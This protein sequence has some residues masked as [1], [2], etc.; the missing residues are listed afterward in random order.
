MVSPWTGRNIPKASTTHLNAMQSK[1]GEGY[2]QVAMSSRGYTGCAS[3][4]MGA[5]P[6]ARMTPTLI[7]EN[8]GNSV[9]NLY[10]ITTNQAAIIAPFR[11]MNRYVGDLPPMLRDKGGHGS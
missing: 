6:I 8:G 9:C 2:G 11:V 4:P 1:P 3:E 7:L 5:R 10:S